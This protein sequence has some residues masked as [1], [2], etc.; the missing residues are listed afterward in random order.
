MSDDKPRAWVTGAGGLIGNYLVRTAAQFAPQYEVIPLLRGD[1]DSTDFAAVEKRFAVEQP[2]LVIHCAAISRAAECAADPVGARKLNVDSAA[3]LAA[4][5][6]K[7][8]FIFFSSDLV[9]DGER[10]K[11]IESDAPNPLNFYAETKVTAEGIVLSNPRHTVVRVGLNSG[12]S[13]TGRRSFNE[14]MAVIW[15]GGG[16][17]KLFIDEFRCPIPAAV[18]A[19]AVWELAAM[20]GGG[21]YHL[22]GSERLSRVEIGRIVAAHYPGLEALRTRLAP[23]LSWPGASRRCLA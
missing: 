14:E 7:C 15:R 4:L 11:Y 20:G 22:A 13:L 1:L 6:E 2:A 23:R 12:Q 19:R 10:G 5:A 3:H 17:I 21:V 8:G 9:F 18:T 16:S